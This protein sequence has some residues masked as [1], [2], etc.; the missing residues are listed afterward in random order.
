MDVSV[1]LRVTTHSACL[2]SNSRQ[3]LYVLRKERERERERERPQDIDYS[4]HLYLQMM[5]VTLPIQAHL[6][7]NNVATDQQKPERSTLIYIS[8]KHKLAG[9]AMIRRLTWLKID[10]ESKGPTYLPLLH[11]ICRIFGNF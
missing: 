1:H 6:P 7:S 4:Y 5:L 8:R 11:E 2:P 9:S 3:V 10:I